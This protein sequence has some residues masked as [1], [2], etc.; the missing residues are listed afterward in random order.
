MLDVIYLNKNIFVCRM[1]DLSSVSTDTCLLPVLQKKFA[2]TPFVIAE[3]YMYN[4]ASAFSFDICIG[5]ETDTEI[6][7]RCT[8]SRAHG[9]S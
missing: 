3:A 1:V 9:R 8:R 7:F 5:G 2:R 6:G 4:E